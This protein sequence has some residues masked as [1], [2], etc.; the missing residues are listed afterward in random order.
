M[1]RILSM[2]LDFKVEGCRYDDVCGTIAGLPCPP[3]FRCILNNPE[4]PDSEGTCC[5]SGMPSWVHL[6]MH[7]HNLPCHSSGL[8]SLHAPPLP[9][10]SCVL[11]YLTR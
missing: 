11:E 9:I 1:L 3:G 4:I 8:P 2:L 10:T 5:A 6:F 7:A